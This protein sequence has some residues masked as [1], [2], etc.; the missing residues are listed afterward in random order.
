MPESVA[1]HWN[2]RGQVDGHMPK[3][4]GVFFVPLLA[5]F[6]AV[7]FLAIPRIDPLKKNIEEFRNNYEKFILLLFVFLLYVYLLTIAWNLGHSFDMFVFLTPGFAVLFFYS[8]V[9]I[10]HAKQNWFIGIRTP[11][12]M[13]NE[14]V[15]N[16]THKL[17]G[18][19]F[20]TSGALAAL[21]VFFES[22][23]FYFVLVPVALGSFYLVIY[24]YLEFQKLENKKIKK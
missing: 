21:G 11:W 16:K 8:G 15:W 3:F 24:S 9:L 13:S 7:L 5:V 10:E 18:K 4:W 22:Y 14:T 23:A 1:S 20:K 17:G 6:L 19:I 2:A 12:T